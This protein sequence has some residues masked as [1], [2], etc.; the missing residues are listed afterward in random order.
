MILTDGEHVAASE[1]V[2]PGNYACLEFGHPMKER[3]QGLHAILDNEILV[4]G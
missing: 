4:R 3:M 2:S 1:T